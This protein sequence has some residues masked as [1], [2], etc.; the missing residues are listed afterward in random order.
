M[1]IVILP[2]LDGTGLLLTE[3]EDILVQ[4]NAVSVI[5]YPPSL[6][7]YDDLHIWLKNVLPDDDFILVAESFSGPLAIMLA[8]QKPLG[9]RGIVF[10]ATFVRSPVR[11]PLFL[12]HAVNII[13]IKST[14]LTWLIQ[15]LL[16]GRWSGKAFTKR[17]RSALKLVPAA[18][19]A[20]RLREVLKVDAREQLRRL[21][22]PVI[23]LRAT[24][25]RLVPSKMSQD[26]DLAPDT[27]FTIEGPHFLLQSRAKQ[28][29][30]FIL[31][32]I[33]ILK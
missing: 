23:Y 22:L 27:V 25:D 20:G 21:S 19:V 28:A 18:T 12:T 33:T 7:R 5:Q 32:F 14:V 15:P 26:F 4:E 1:K 6:Y 2:G 16:M 10:V 13:P 24:Q 30:A 17:F 31:K 3:L 8:S 9:L 29:A 11:L